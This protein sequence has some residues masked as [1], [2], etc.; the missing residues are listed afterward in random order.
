[1]SDDV[2]RMFRQLV[3]VLRAGS[4]ERLAQPFDVGELYQ[5]I[6]PYRLHRRDLGLETNQDYE[7]ALT[8]LLSGAGGYLQVEE[9]MADTLTRELASPNPDLGAFRQFATA[10]IM[11]SP[12]ALA[13]V[14][15]EH[16][17]PARVTPPTMPVA[18]PPGGAMNAS[19]SGGTSPGHPAVRAQVVPAAGESCRYCGGELPAGRPITYCPSCGQDQTIHHCEACGAEL[20]VGWKYCPTCGKSVAAGPA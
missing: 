1:M 4:P 19:A 7:L 8:Q 18:S 3:H 10:Q 17:R 5:T 2:E 16:P 20:D 15:A 13:R 6:L 14:S 9:R 12:D 11:I